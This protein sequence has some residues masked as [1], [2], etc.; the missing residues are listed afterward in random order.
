METTR[1]VD[2]HLEQHGGS[3][4]DVATSKSKFGSHDSLPSASSTSS[5]AT[6]HR[7]GLRKSHC[8]VS[9]S[10]LS[11]SVDNLK[12]PNRTSRP[13]L[14]K[15]DLSLDSNTGRHRRTGHDA[16]S[17][18]EDEDRTSADEDSAEEDGDRSVRPGVRDEGGG[19]IELNESANRSTFYVDKA[20][21]ELVTT[22][23]TYVRDLHEV[24]QVAVLVLTI[25]TSAKRLCFLHC[26]SICL[27]VCLLATLRK[28]S[29][30]DLREI[31]REVGQ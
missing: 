25:V 17:A 19:K 7:H 15:L 30:T 16:S 5:S 14:R 21:D 9:D 26:L 24:I 29:Q 12:N 18:T 4:V 22:E 13:R 6:P 1:S 28:N 23:R 2:D 31:F 10:R 3:D 20:V 11:S 8:S 27:F